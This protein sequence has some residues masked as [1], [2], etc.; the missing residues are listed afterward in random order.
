[1]LDTLKQA[2]LTDSEAKI[3][4]TLLQ[5]GSLTKTPLVKHAGISPS[6][7]YEVADKLSKK[8]LVSVVLHNGTQ[9]F[10]AAPPIKIQ[11]YLESKKQAIAVAERNV[12]AILPKL[13]ALSSG[14][15]AAVDINVFTGWEGIGTAYTQFALQLPLK[16]TVY[17]IG[18]SPGSEADRTVRFF[19]NYVEILERRKAVLR[20]IFKEEARKYA[21]QF[22][23]EYPHAYKYR[24]YLFTQSLAEVSVAENTV[25]I[26]S[27]E[28]EPFV[29]RIINKQCADLFRQ[30]FEK[31]WAIAKE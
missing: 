5:K 19:M 4:L 11:E 12:D 28:K 24:R 2:G 17:A 22:V 9:T 27:L 10:T 13:L 3:Y 7:V 20:V 8:G 23:K 26:L 31:L 18:A 21:E 15:T 29:I 25:L 1:M 14:T 6:K 30:Y 16:G